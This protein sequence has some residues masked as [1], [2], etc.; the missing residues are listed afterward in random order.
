LHVQGLLADQQSQAE[1]AKQFIEDTSRELILVAH[2]L[3]IARQENGE[4]HAMLD[5]AASDLERTQVMRNACLDERVLALQER[6]ALHTAQIQ[7]LKDQLAVAQQLHHEA[8]ESGLQ[9][10]RDQNSLN[11]ACREMSVGNSGNLRRAMQLE[12]DKALLIL[13]A[14]RCQARVI[15][16]DGALREAQDTLGRSQE[17]IAHL[18]EAEAQH[19]HVIAQLK[20][21]LAST[22]EHLSTM[23]TQLRKREEEGFQLTETKTQHEEMIARVEKELH[24]TKEHL[25][26]TQTDLLQTQD[27]LKRTAQDLQAELAGK[28]DCIVQLQEQLA[29]TKS[30]LQVTQ[31]ELQHVLNTLTMTTARLQ[32]ETMQ[33][34]ADMQ[35]TC[36]HQ[37]NLN[38]MQPSLRQQHAEA[39]S[40][41]ADAAVDLEIVLELG[42]LSSQDAEVL[43]IAVDLQSRHV[44]ELQS[45]LERSDKH[46]RV[47][48]CL[49]HPSPHNA[50][51]LC[52]RHVV[53]ILSWWPRSCKMNSM[54]SKLSIQSLPRPI[55]SSQL[56]VILE[57][58]GYSAIVM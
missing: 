8:V 11:Q 9:L 3:Q 50:R 51:Q 18:T 57:R 5:A 42:R 24:D 4:I 29:M 47:R 39:Q 40:K 48:A 12:E 2:Q 27:E 52:Q 53:L 33:M 21:E 19:E 17:E 41:L 44:G 38:K 20:G 32:A 37:S 16:S 30:K 10:Q 36:T 46:A 28:V 43:K 56:C 31:R 34:A 6:E 23:Q 7:S 35:A 49:P 22:K 45:Q 54:L 26:T 25:A 13:E 58:Y 55:T 1:R 14:A 15:A